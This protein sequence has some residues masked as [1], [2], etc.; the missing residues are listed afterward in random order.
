MRAPIR[1]GR[2][3]YYHTNGD[4]YSEIL[5][6]LNPKSFVIS[7]IPPPPDGQASYRKIKEIC[8]KR[9]MRTQAIKLQYVLSLSHTHILSFIFPSILRIQHKNEPLFIIRIELLV[10]MKTNDD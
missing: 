6:K 1:F 9:G 5:S 8:T 10:V 2:I 3:S 7:F 4:N